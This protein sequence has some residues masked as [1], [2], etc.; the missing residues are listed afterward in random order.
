MLENDFVTKA[1]KT[2]RPWKTTQVYN[3]A[4]KAV[5]KQG[6]KVLDYGSGPYQHVKQHIENLGATYFPYDS[7]GN[8]GTLTKNNDV[9]MGSNVLNVAVYSDDPVKAYNN[10]LDEM[11]SALSPTGTLIVNMPTSGP[12]A[13]WMSPTQL[14]EDLIKR[15]REVLHAAKETFIARYP[16]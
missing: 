11:K 2:A 13:D 4:L 6:D 14:K 15:F 5:V 16:R 10:S 9:V 8:I 12:K 7:Y 1:G 3:T